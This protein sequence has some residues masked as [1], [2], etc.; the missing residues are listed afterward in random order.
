VR[1]QR[2]G[3]HQR[4]GHRAGPSPSPLL[5]SAAAAE[6]LARSRGGGEGGCGG[7]GRQGRGDWGGK[8]A[9]VQGET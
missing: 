7:V 3:R 6:E 2:H 4:E 1:A 5:C 8:E 9:R